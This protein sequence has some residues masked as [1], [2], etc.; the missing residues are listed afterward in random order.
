MSSG[1]E[2]VL[3]QGDQ[4][5]QGWAYLLVASGRQFRHTYAEHGKKQN[6]SVLTSHPRSRRDVVAVRVDGFP[7]LPL[8]PTIEHLLGLD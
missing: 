2:S 8:H 4:G 5:K 6:R 3:L 7:E 1:I